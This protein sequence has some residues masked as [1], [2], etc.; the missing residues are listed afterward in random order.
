[1]RFFIKKPQEIKLEVQHGH[2][3]IYYLRDIKYI[4]RVIHK[5]AN[6]LP[7]KKND[8]DWLQL[9]IE[10]FL[11]LNSRFYEDLITDLIKEVRRYHILPN[12]FSGRNI[13][14]KY[15]N[16]LS[17]KYHE[18]KQLKRNRATHGSNY[19]RIGIP[20]FDN[21]V[22]P[23][24][25]RYKPTDRP[26]LFNMA[27]RKDFIRM[28]QNDM[29]EC[30]DDIENILREVVSKLNSFERNAS[31]NPNNWKVRKGMD[32]KKLFKDFEE[33]NKKYAKVRPMKGMSELET[34]Q[35]ITEHHE[36]VEAIIDKYYVRSNDK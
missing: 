5:I 9:Y 7:D 35:A 25:L 3:G 20:E 36:A 21:D 11:I 24:P 27:R 18:E 34:L 10:S 14:E 16:S 29:F 12:D 15:K 13:L 28:W 22:L 6:Q 33:L 2:E 30:A 26:P 32:D 4:V 19:Q 8:I 1:M 31:Y 23:K 17:S